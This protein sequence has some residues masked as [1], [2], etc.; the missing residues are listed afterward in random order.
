MINAFLAMLQ[1]RIIGEN[2]IIKDYKKITTE[3]EI[4]NLGQLFA[5]SNQFLG[6]SVNGIFDNTENK[7][8]KFT[9]NNIETGDTNKFAICKDE[10]KKSTIQYDTTNKQIRLKIYIDLPEIYQEG[11]KA[12]NE[13]NKYIGFSIALYIRNYDDWK[14]L[15]EWELS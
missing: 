9:N 6:I 11:G 7:D 10:S 8:L 15:C 2:D 12:I 1:L 5:G 13:M 4:D 14:D 3:T